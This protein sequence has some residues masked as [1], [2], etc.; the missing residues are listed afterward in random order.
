[1]CVAISRA[2]YALVE[3]TVATRTLLPR[4]P[5][6][7]LPAQASQ[8]FA[9]ISRMVIVPGKIVGIFIASAMKKVHM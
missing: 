2:A 8:N 7:R 6:S 1:M 3:Y 4:V 5:R 9:M